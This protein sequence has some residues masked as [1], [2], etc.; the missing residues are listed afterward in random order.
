MDKFFKSTTIFSIFFIAFVS[1]YIYKHPFNTECVDVIKVS[2]II[3][4]TSKSKSY[5][6]TV[7]MSDGL[8]YQMNSRNISVEDIYCKKT[9]VT[10]KSLSGEEDV[11]EV[12]TEPER[13]DLKESF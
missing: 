2:K 4:M 3:S 5:Q 10:R 8:Q 1:V 13:L 7:I 9:K 12:V 6:T 11:Y